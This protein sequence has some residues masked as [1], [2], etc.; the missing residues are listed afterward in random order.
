[1]T[2]EWCRFLLLTLNSDLAFLLKP[3]NCDPIIVIGIYHEFQNVGNIFVFFTIRYSN[4]NKWLTLF[5]KHSISP[6]PLFLLSAWGDLKSHR[7]LPV[8]V[9]YQ[10]R[11]CKM[12]YGFERSISNVDLGLFQPKNQLMF[13][14]VTFW[15]W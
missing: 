4:Q 15:F 6:S 8:G 11:L 13:S 1:M 10:K 12:K 9:S 14:F 5:K 7:Y 2:Q 3:F